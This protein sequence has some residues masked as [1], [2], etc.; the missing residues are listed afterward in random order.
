MLKIEFNQQLFDKHIK[1]I[2]IKLKK[3]I[4]AIDTNCLNS[5]SAD[6]LKNL[7]NEK[8]IANLLSA[9]SF[10]LKLYIEYFTTNYPMDFG[11]KGQKKEDWTKLYKIF[12]EDIFEKEYKNWGERTQEYG[13]Y[14]F[15]E[16]LGLKTCPYCNRNYTFVVDEENGKLRPEID[17][18]YPKSLYPFLAMSFY[19]LIPSCQICNHTKSNTLKDELEN[20]Y[21]ITP[22]S[23]KFTY[24]P[25]N[26]DFTLVEN[27]K[28]NFDNFEINIV[29]KK[30]NLELF[31]LNELYK[32]HK[33]IVLELFIKKVYYPKSYIK[34]LEDFGFSQ[35]EIYRYL[36]CNYQKDEDLHKRPLSKLIKDISEEL[37]LV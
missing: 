26:I 25:K 12:R 7:S 23:Y 14:Y 35:D 10:Q 33:D 17:H 9:N 34:E 2:S 19:N 36:L 32:Q 28:Y 22:N 5:E 3:A 15:V 16:K 18:F 6:C 37:G 1:D 21:D 8:E 4:E 31:K 29:G 27:N 24:I 30:D 20:P 13:A 11:I